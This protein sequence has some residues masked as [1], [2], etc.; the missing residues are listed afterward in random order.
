M[1]KQRW[2]TAPLKCICG[3]LRLPILTVCYMAA[4]GRILLQHYLPFVYQAYPFEVVYG[5]PPPSLL[6]YILATAHTAAIEE[7]LI[8]RD[9]VL[10]EVRQGLMGAQ[11]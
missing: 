11:H 4:L 8:S 7:A 2:S 10:R 1:A 5:R 3:I 6:S 9:K